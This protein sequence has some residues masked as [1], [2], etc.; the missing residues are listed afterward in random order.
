MDA[1][2]RRKPLRRSAVAC[3]ETVERFTVG[4]VQTAAPG[5]QEF[6]A[7]AGHAIVEGYA[8]PGLG[9]NFSRQQPAGT[10]ADDGNGFFIPHG[11][12]GYLP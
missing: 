10:G 8:L 9:Q 7:D 2:K 5:H 11:H 1:D 6:A 4:E 3:N 12:E